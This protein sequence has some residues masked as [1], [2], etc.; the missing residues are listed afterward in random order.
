MTSDHHQRPCIR[1]HAEFT[2]SASGLCFYC[3]PA[4]DVQIIG[5]MCRIGAVS[6][7]P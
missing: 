6:T 2:R 5:D 1:C 4:P 3:R 7:S